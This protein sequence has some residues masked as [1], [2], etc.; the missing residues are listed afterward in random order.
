MDQINK[1]LKSICLWCGQP[2]NIIWVHGHGQCSVCGYN[3]DECCKGENCEQPTELNP[4]KE[5]TE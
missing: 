4:T 1:N 2:T 3:I 5:E